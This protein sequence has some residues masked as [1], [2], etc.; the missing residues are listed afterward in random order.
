MIGWSPH[1]SQ[2][3]ACQRGTATKSIAEAFGKKPI[4]E[5]NV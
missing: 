2:Q 5:S 4:N 3:K 1:E